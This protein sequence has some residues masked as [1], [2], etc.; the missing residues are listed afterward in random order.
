MQDFAAWLVTSETVSLIY[1]L[2]MVAVMALPMIGLSVWY[3]GG[4]KKTP[5]GRKLMAD[6]NSSAN[7][8][9]LHA[10]GANPFSQFKAALGLHSGIMSGSYGEDAKRKQI[11]VYKVCAAWLGALAFFGSVPYLIA[12]YAGI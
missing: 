2:F 8:P 9:V 11:I 7:R 6:Q 5:G 4:I 3:H 10:P 12:W 1:A